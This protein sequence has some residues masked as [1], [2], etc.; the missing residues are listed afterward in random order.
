MRIIKNLGRLVFARAGYNEGNRYSA[1][2]Q[3]GVDQEN[4][5]G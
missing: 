1:K 5:L 3:P 2:E 4:A